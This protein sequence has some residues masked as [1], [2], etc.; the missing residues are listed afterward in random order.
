MTLDVELGDQDSA[1]KSLA[2]QKS[3]LAKEKAAREKAQVEAKT[4]ARAV[5]DLWKMTNRFT[6]Q[7]PA[8]EEKVKHMDNKVLDGL[9]ELRTKELDLE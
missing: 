4:L 7:V 2:A 5:D 6:T 3:E 9:T 1:T 8:L